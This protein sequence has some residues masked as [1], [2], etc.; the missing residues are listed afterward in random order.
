MVF[1]HDQCHTGCSAAAGVLQ[2]L[3]VGRKVKFSVVYELPA[4]LFAHVIHGSGND[5]EKAFGKIVV[6]R[7]DHLGAN[8]FRQ[9]GKFLKI[10]LGLYASAQYPA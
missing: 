4:V 3:H 10:L 1:R 7:N 6:M 9:R 8:R 5:F 2:S